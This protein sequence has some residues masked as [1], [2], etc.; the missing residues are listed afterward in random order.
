LAKDDEKKIRLK[1]F[2]SLEGKKSIIIKK[3]LHSIAFTKEFTKKDQDEKELTFRILGYSA[4]EET[5]DKLKEMIQKRG[6]MQGGK[7]RENKLLAVRALENINIPG[8]LPLLEE[9]SLD[10]SSL[11]STRA[12]KALVSLRKG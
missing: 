4:D 8:A 2:H 9:L 11:I 12:K 5:L 3:F 1:A 10:S 6:F 7:N